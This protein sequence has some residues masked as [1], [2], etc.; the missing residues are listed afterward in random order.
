MKKNKDIMKTMF[1]LSTWATKDIKSCDNS[2]AEVKPKTLNTLYM[3]LCLLNSHDA[4]KSPLMNM[5]SH[6]HSHN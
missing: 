1:L 2:R 3:C 5:Y 4:S 6:I